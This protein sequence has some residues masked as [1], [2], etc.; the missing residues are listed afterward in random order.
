VQLDIK[1]TLRELSRNPGFVASALAV[2]ALTRGLSSA[3][4]SLFDAIFL[5]PL[6]YP[7]V[8]SIVQIFSSPGGSSAMASS[9]KFDLWQQQDTLTDLSAYV[10][11][12]ISIQ[13]GEEGTGQI[14][15]LR[16]TGKYFQ[17]F[18]IK[19][20]WQIANWR[21]SRS[22]EF[23]ACCRRLNTANHGDIQRESGGPEPKY[24][25]RRR[26]PELV[27]PG[28]GFI[29]KRIE[30]VVADRVQ[31][32][33]LPFWVIMLLVFTLACANL[34]ILFL[35]HALNKGD[36]V[37]IRAA[38]GAS[39]MALVRQAFLPT[40]L[41][42]AT[43]GLIGLLIGH[44]GLR[45]FL[46]RV[47]VSRLPLHQGAL[48]LN[49]W[50]FLFSLALSALA[51]FVISGLP[52]IELLRV[53]IARA[54]KGVDGSSY[55][56][57]QHRRIVSILVAA[58]I[59]VTSGF[60]IPSALLIQAFAALRSVNPGFD[61]SNVVAFDMLLT[62]SPARNTASIS[63]LI[64]AVT[65]QLKRQPGVDA[66]SLTCCLPTEGGFVSSRQGWKSSGVRVPVPSIA[67]IQTV[68]IS[69]ACGGNDA[70]LART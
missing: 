24:Q 11:D 28:Q 59:C 70:R 68:S 17:V 3:I 2:L 38:L 30:D 64:K 15:A 49:L 13:V 35:G 36:E 8:D 37:A 21:F 6:A 10:P 20:L 18:G 41:L 50:V 55:R 52:A 7:G 4:F 51:A 34:S 22:G 29:A 61:P 48:P 58:E 26:Y 14:R 67:C 53:D 46:S 1:W 9:A 19:L 57:L 5:H 62:P 12:P 45:L 44:A 16:V 56:G 32:L 47:D 54:L 31:H 60:L 69:G 66:I 65:P 33:A 23:A 42:C 40:I 25:F 39:R 43:G 27:R 63:Q